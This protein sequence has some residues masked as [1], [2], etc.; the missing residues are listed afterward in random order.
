MK[1]AEIDFTTVPDS[2]GEV[3]GEGKKA[4]KVA[5]H[6]CNTVWQA[7]V[8]GA[9]LPAHYLKAQL[10]AHQQ[11]KEPQ[12]QHHHHLLVYHDH[13]TAWFNQLS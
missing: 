8:N 3:G 12:H 4:G 2:T 7:V 1:F 9:V 6:M 11:H 13:D 5:T 10:A